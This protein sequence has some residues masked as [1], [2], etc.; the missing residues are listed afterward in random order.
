M[1]LLHGSDPPH[2]SL[3]P[4][5]WAVPRIDH[6]AALSL[7]DRGHKEL[8]PRPWLQRALGPT[9]QEQGGDLASPLCRTSSHD[10]VIGLSRAEG[11]CQWGH[12]N[13][14]KTLDPVVP[15]I[16][17]C[18]SVVLPSYSI[19]TSCSGETAVHV[20][21]CMRLCACEC[22]SIRVWSCVQSC[23]CTGVQGLVG[24]GLEWANVHR[25]EQGVPVLRPER[26]AAALRTLDSQEKVEARGD[27]LPFPSP[28][29]T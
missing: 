11:Q 14:V 8:P 9:S 29:S 20:C 26:G 24:I 12:Q 10:L 25:K 22:L 4:L 5:I 23:F 18:N 19:D 15:L 3:T 17:K 2:S 7:R 21:E 13:S 28:G 6:C 16:D 1:S 27:T